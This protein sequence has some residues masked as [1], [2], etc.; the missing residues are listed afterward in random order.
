MKEI[1]AYQ[2]DDGKFVG[3]YEE[4]LEY[5]ENLVVEMLYE[6][7]IKEFKYS[8]YEYN[9]SVALDDSSDIRRFLQNQDVKELFYLLNG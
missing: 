2:S 4:V 6:N 5:E 1:I 8:C 7:I 9:W 3:T